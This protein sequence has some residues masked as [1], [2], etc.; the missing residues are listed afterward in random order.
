[1]PHPPMS[2]PARAAHSQSSTQDRPM[3][4]PSRPIASVYPPGSLADEQHGELALRAADTIAAVPSSHPSH[5]PND[6]GAP[7]DYAPELIAERQRFVE[8]FT[9]VRLQHVATYSVAPEEARGNIENFTGVAQ[10]P[11][12]I[13]GPLRVNGEYAKGDFL[14]PLATTE[15]SLVASYSR[16]MKVLTLAG[17]VT[18]TISGGGMQR[19][20][21]FEFA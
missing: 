13:A 15:G 20:P 16:G 8:M 10:V 17:G 12:G 4:T 19:A 18:T 6:K 5:I 11:L 7:R 1:M 3:A 2:P 9:G 21:V 14:I